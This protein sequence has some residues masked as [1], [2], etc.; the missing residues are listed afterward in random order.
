MLVNIAVVMGYGYSG[1]WLTRNAYPSEDLPMTTEDFIT[2][3]FCQVD[4]RMRNV[5]NHRQAA[6]WPSEVVTIGLLFAI[7]GVGQQA[8][9]LWLKRDCADC[10]PRLTERARLFRRLRN[11]WEWT[12]MFLAKPSLLA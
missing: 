11:H 6:L 9:Y 4:D 10:F 3:L 1:K 12:L 2:A 7:K 8:F 5:P